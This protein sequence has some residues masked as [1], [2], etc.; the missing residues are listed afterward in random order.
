[1]IIN[2]KL[3][4]ASS[5]MVLITCITVYTIGKTL[6]T[7]ILI[8]SHCMLVFINLTTKTKEQK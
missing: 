6:I 7:E 4:V 5:F 2:D 3:H 8:S 1:M